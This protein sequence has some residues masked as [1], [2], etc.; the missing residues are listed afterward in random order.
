M[1]HLGDELDFLAD[2]KRDVWIDRLASLSARA[3]GRR[4]RII[5]FHPECCSTEAVTVP[6]GDSAA[7][8]STGVVRQLEFVSAL[9]LTQFQVWRRIVNRKTPDSKLA[10]HFDTFHRL[11]LRV[12]EDVLHASHAAFLRD[13]MSVAIALGNRATHD[14]TRLPLQS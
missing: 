5:E 9:T 1:T 12:A 11:S 2:S 10:L 3:F 13:R 14:S 8:I 4:A 7:A 6:P